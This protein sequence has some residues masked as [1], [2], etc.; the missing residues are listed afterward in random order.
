M[1]PPKIIIA[2]S[3]RDHAAHVVGILV[4]ESGSIASA[5]KKANLDDFRLRRILDDRALQIDLIALWDRMSERG[6]WRLHPKMGVGPAQAAADGL[7]GIAGGARS[8]AWRFG[9]ELRRFVS[10]WAGISG[11]ISDRYLCALEINFQYQTTAK[12][13]RWR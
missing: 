5:A 9:F 6:S 13:R 3:D 8:A 7:I 12:K 4:N 10:V 1:R 2:Q 11:P